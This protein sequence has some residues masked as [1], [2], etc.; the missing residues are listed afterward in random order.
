MYLELVFLPDGTVMVER[1]TPAQNDL[2]LSIFGDSIL[3]KSSFQQ[4]ISM[5]E[6]AEMLIGETTFCG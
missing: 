2:L 4:F 6:D 1:G 5:T 3:D